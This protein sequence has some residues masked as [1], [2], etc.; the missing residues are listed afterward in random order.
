VDDSTPDKFSLLNAK[1]VEVRSADVKEMIKNKQLKEGDK[2]DFNVSELGRGEYYL[3]SF[4]PKHPD[5][6]K[7]LEKIKVILQ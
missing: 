7:R 2:I 3:H 5:K 1:G 6:D 4:A